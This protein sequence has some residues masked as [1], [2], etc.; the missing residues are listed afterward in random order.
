MCILITGSSGYFGRIVVRDLISNGY[1]VV[2]IDIRRDPEQ[3][4]GEQFRF[5][6]CCITDRK[7]LKEIFEREQPTDVLHFA[8][9][10][11]KVRDR[12]RE[13]EIDVG[14]SINVL[15]TSNETHS[16]RRLIYSS[17]AA[18]Y[19]AGNHNGLWIS[20]TEPVNPGRYRY[21]VNKR[22]IEEAFFSTN[23][24]AGLQIVSLRVCTVVGPVYSKPRSVVSIL[25]RMPVLPESFRKKKVQF[26][27]EEDFVRIIREIIRDNDIEGI[28]NCAADSFSVVGEV[29]PGKRYINIPVTGLKPLLWVL[30]NLRILN[31]QPVSLR[32][33]LYPV[34]L[35]PT[36]LAKR[37]GYSFRYSSSESFADTVRNNRLPADAKF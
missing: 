20:E 15:E 12:K 24:R 26:M 23:R 2:G 31:L 7:K 16:V 5:Y 6:D 35:D 13:Y 17:S 29:V 1:R 10:F 25:I 22:L 11:N 33:C 37:Y 34:L 32:Y 19:G 8:C 9:T 36:R 3:T 4:E 21:G 30:W 18:I 14:G 27:H 28:F